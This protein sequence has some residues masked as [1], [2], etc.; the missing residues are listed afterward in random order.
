MPFVFL[1]ALLYPHST[2][3]ISTCMYRSGGILP[4]ISG[5]SRA[6]KRHARGFGARGLHARAVDSRSST[7]LT[8]CAGRA[9]GMPFTPAQRS[10]CDD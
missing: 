3:F 4:R 2:Q 10:A 8:R 6:S 9:L 1:C 7:A 5:V